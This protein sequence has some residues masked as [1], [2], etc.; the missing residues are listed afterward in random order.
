MRKSFFL[1]FFLSLVLFECP[2]I[3]FY[4]FRKLSLDNREKFFINF[5]KKDHI[6]N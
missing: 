6:L 5:E 2:R 3:P 1:A 4:S